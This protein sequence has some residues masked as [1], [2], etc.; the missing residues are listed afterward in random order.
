MGALIVGPK[1]T[2][3]YTIPYLG[4]PFFS[5][6]HVMP[7]PHWVM[8]F[9]KFQDALVGWTS[10]V[11][12]QCRASKF[13]VKSLKVRLD[14]LLWKLLMWKML[15][16][17]FLQ[18]WGKVQTT[19]QWK[20]KLDFPSWWRIQTS[21]QWTRMLDLSSRCFTFDQGWLLHCCLGKL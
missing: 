20:G 15:F 19:L 17:D 9:A 4:R 10:I 12:H 3:K 16:C 13:R 6:T 14:F 11:T 7:I 5:N 18:W 1:L 21:I 8:C 2:K